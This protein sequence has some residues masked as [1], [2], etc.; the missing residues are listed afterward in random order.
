MFT[1]DQAQSATSLE[2]Q[3]SISVRL[4]LAYSVVIGCS[5]WVFFTNRKPDLPADF[6][7]C[8][9]YDAWDVLWLQKQLKV[10][11]VDHGTL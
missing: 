4:L 7:I 9:I 6:S 1:A 2:F 3:I 8:E 11:L 10:Q 5:L